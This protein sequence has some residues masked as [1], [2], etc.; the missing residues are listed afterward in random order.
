L[1]CLQ[2]MRIVNASGTK[3]IIL[4]PHQIDHFNRVENIILQ[5][6]CYFDLSVMGSGKSYIAI[7][8]AMKYNLPIGVCCPKTAEPVWR[9][10]CTQYDVDLKFIIGYQSLRSTTGKQPKHGFLH[11]IDSDSGTY[12]SAS[13]E[14]M[15]IA[16]QGLLLVLDEFQNIKNNSDQYKACKALTTACLSIKGNC[17]FAL[18]SGAPFDKEEHVINA[19]KLI[20]YI[21]HPILYRY[22][23][24]TADL[25]LYG[26][27][28]LIDVCKNFDAEATQKVLLTYPIDHR[29]VQGLCYRLYVEVLKSRIT[30]AMP[31][32]KIEAEKD[33]KN[34]YYNM[35]VKDAEDLVHAIVELSRA[36]RFNPVTLAYDSRNASWGAITTALMHIEACKLKTLIRLAKRDLDHDPNC[37]VILFVNYVISIKTLQQALVEY[38]PLIMYGVTSDRE[39]TNIVKE[40][41]TN[42][43]NRLLIANTRV[44]GVSISLDDKVGDHPRYTYIIPTYSIL[45]LHQATGRTHRDGTRS[46]ATIRFV[47]GKV[48]SRETSILNALARKNKVLRETLDTQ[49]E[50]GIRFPGEYDDEIEADPINTPLDDLK[51]LESFVENNLVENTG[52]NNLEVTTIQDNL[53][54]IIE[55]TVH[56]ESNFNGGNQ[57]TKHQI[58]VQ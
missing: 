15:K 34:G 3:S 52:H 28:E 23:K 44:G 33:I 45:D 24:E 55:N 38:D 54:P 43:K 26:A 57:T 51:K 21:Q 42:M 18:L 25:K 27:Q 6:H 14:F 11:R 58:K 53:N 37:K 39:R 32:P 12:F 30:S 16:R 22:F 31:P 40:F 50:N 46:K 1:Y 29:N 17:R 47:Y 2:T 36:A 10:V 9:H 35:D 41:Q 19:M 8:L 7:A 20:G 56:N 4:R 48:G 49:V 5:N 13:E